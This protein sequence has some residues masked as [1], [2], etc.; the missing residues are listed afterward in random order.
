MAQDA[1]VSCALGPNDGKPSFGPLC[2]I[3]VFIST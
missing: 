2:N 3:F 1:L